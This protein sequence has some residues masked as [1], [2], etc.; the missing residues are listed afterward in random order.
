MDYKLPTK[1]QPFGKMSENIR[2]VLSPLLLPKSETTHLPPL[3]SHHH[4]T[5]S[6]VTSKHIILPRH[7]FSPPNDC[8]AP[9]I[10]FLFNF[11][12]LPNSLHYITGGEGFLTHTVHSYLHIC[13]CCLTGRANFPDLLQVTLGHALQKV[14]FWMLLKQNFL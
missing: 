13:T 6:N 10:Q 3:K 5:P 7:N 9:L 8:P 12:A 11:G 2:A 4:L 1:R 14:N